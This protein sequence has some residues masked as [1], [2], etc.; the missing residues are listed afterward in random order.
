MKDSQA[1]VEAYMGYLESLRKSDDE[2]FLEGGQ[3][4]MEKT[5]S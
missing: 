5:E 4:E 2:Y 3:V 1:G